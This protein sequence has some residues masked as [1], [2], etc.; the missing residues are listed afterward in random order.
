MMDS[1]PPLR[2]IEE[3]MKDPERMHPIGEI[4]DDTAHEARWNAGVTA[5]EAYERMLARRI[6]THP[7]Y[8]LARCATDRYTHGAWAHLT[9]GDPDAAIVLLAPMI[10]LYVDDRPR[11]MPDH[12]WPPPNAMKLWILALI[13]SGQVLR[14]LVGQY[15]FIL[16]RYVRGVEHKSDVTWLCQLF[17]ERYGR[18]TAST[19]QVS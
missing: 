1:R 12:L 17:C 18:R 16:D 5:V 10:R 13:E 2:W 19:L 15:V 11:G 6:L 8:F 7:P 4:L 9:L 14:L 3:T